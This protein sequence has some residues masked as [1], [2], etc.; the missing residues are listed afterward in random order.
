MNAIKT[1]S[2]RAENVHEGLK[3]KSFG[4]KDIKKL[5]DKYV[6]QLRYWIELGLLS[7]STQNAVGQDKFNFYEFLW[8]I[9]VRELKDLNFDNDIIK[10]CAKEVFSRPDSKYSMLEF[11][12]AILFTLLNR[13][14]SFFVISK[15][16]EFEV[17]RPED[18]SKLAEKRGFET[19]VILNILPL[20][21]GFLYLGDFRGYISSRRLLK[22]NELRALQILYNS[23]DA[24][25]KIEL[26]NKTVT[27][28][29]GKEAAL[30]FINAVF[31]QEA[32][33]QKISIQL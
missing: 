7:E 29:P 8:V 26:N 11:E 22:E 4:I 30:E 24:S 6:R 1:L 33:K 23:K 18:L 12:K 10:K 27:I 15:N 32:K 13:M 28:K 19:C 3:Q 14:D 25:V 20:V 17:Y 16:G 21:R 31:M 9:I 2:D 5:D